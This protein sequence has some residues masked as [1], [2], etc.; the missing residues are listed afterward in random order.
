[1][2]H[3]KC[4]LGGS[5]CMYSVISKTT[6]LFVREVRALRIFA[7]SV[8][9]RHRAKKCAIFSCENIF[10]Y[11]CIETVV[12][13]GFAHTLQIFVDR[14]NSFHQLWGSNSARL[15]HPLVDIKIE[16]LSQCCNE[17]LY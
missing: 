9:P 13:V 1:M 12:R 3:D 15:L 5:I 17:V 14:R 7:L 10:C 6:V 11:Y 16:T 4:G 2:V 8:A